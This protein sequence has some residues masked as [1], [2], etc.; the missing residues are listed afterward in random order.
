[1][2]HFSL[3][4][5]LLFTWILSI[6]LGSCTGCNVP[7]A[8]TNVPSSVSKLICKACFSQQKLIK[9]FNGSRVYLII[10]AITIPESL[11]LHLDSKPQVD[12]HSQLTPCDPLSSVHIPSSLIIWQYILPSI[13]ILHVSSTI[14]KK[15]I[16]LLH[17]FIVCICLKFQFDYISYM[18]GAISIL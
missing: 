14:Y 3:H 5:A 15:N 4:S 12:I 13:S 16:K 18:T 2:R 10:W 8:P 17:N 9:V 1:M 11:C 6:I 7:H